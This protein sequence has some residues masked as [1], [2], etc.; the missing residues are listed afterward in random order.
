MIQGMTSFSWPLVIC[1]IEMSLLLLSPVAVSILISLPITDLS[2]GIV[3]PSP[4][5]TASVMPLRVPSD[6]AIASRMTCI[7]ATPYSG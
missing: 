7:A 4:E 3:I 5:N 6:L 1:R 2:A